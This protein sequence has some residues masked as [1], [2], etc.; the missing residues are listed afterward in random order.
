M[1]AVIGVKNE[2][3]NQISYIN[4]PLQI[5][6]GDFVIVDEG[7]GGY[8]YEC[9]SSKQPYNQYRHKLITQCVIK[10]ANSQELAQYIQNQLHVND[11]VEVFKNMFNEF[12]I[13]GSLL[14]IEIS[15]DNRNIRYTYFSIFTLK[16]P[17]MI[18]YLL[19]NNPRRF[20]IEFYQVGERE[21]FSKNGGVGV[22]GYELCCHKRS[23]STPTISTSLLKEIGI[24]V[25]LKINRSG[26]CSKYKCCLLFDAEELI[27]LQ[28]KLPDLNH[29]IEYLGKIYTVSAI[30]IREQKVILVGD[31][32]IEISF[33]YFRRM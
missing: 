13:N 23:Y 5:D 20:N 32:Q 11:F 24:D 2:I 16:F 17:Q 29:P 9:V 1:S 28:A 27:D 14:G 12:D 30:V 8:I 15:L 25:N 21:Y 19:T 3:T 4:T 22:C 6:I 33:D 18:K 10:K 7:K 26:T 31:K